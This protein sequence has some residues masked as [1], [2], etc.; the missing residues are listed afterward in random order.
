M[1]FKWPKLAS[2]TQKTGHLRCLQFYMF[3]SL[4]GNFFQNLLKGGA[5]II[6]L[7]RLDI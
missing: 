3:I 2:S 7:D 6:Y 4:E 5:C 1:R